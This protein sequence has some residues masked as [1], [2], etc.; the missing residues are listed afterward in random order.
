MRF[1]TIFPVLAGLVAVFLMYQNVSAAFLILTRIGTLSTS[2]QVYTSWTY[3]GAT[4]PDF[5]GTATPGAMVAITVNAITTTTSAD[6]AGSWQSAPNNIVTGTNS[7][8]IASGNEVVAF[9]LVFSPAATPTVTPTATPSALP[10][11]G[12]M[13]WPLGLIAV[14]LMVF[15][16]GRNAKDRLDEHYWG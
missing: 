1:K 12:I 9:S 4:A 8:S 5:A 14:G 2:G 11:A 7:V 13:I 3:T 15:F 6:V 16:T 10:E